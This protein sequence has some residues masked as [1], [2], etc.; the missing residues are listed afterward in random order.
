MTAGRWS[1]SCPVRIP[2]GWP[3]TRP[4]TSIGT[5]LPSDRYSA[6]GEEFAWVGALFRW[7]FLGFRL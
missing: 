4:P 5:I 3:T 1:W 6:F 7:W 2:P